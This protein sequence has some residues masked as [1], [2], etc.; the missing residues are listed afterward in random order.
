MQELINLAGK[1]R[2]DLVSLRGIYR[3][4]QVGGPHQFW[5]T[6]PCR[7]KERFMLKFYDQRFSSHNKSA[8]CAKARPA[9][10]TTRRPP[11]TAKHTGMEDRNNGAQFKLCLECIGF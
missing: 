1:A 11:G 10:S 6:T 7:D 9:V 3:A 4:D 2:G 5:Q 8:R